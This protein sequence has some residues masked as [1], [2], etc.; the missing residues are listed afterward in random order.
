MKSAHRIKDDPMLHLVL[1]LTDP[2]WASMAL[3]VGVQKLHEY[4]AHKN[5]RKRSQV[6]SYGKLVNCYSI[7][8]D[9][10][11]EISVMGKLRQKPKKCKAR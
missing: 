11:Q 2:Y 5:H 9:Q 3:A 7:N 6:L 1:G 4:Q 8:K 10:L